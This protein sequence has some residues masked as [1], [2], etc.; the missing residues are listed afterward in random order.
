[1]EKKEKSI[2]NQKRNK[3]SVSFTLTP[4]VNDKLEELSKKLGTSRS[5]VVSMAIVELYEKRK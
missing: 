2:E 4:E 5:S 1:M 3:P